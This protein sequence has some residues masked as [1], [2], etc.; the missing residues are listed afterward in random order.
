MEPQYN[1]IFKGKIVNGRDPEYAKNV[2]AA[3][4]KQKAP[5]VLASMNGGAPYIRKNLTLE[6]ARKFKAVFDKAGAR[7]QVVKTFKCPDCGHI[8]KTDGQC[9]KCMNLTMEFDS[10]PETPPADAPSA[11][12]GP[13]RTAA[14][15]P[16]PVFSTKKLNQFATYK[17]VFKGGIQP[18]FDQEAVKSNLGNEFRADVFKVNAP[19]A[20]GDDYHQGQLNGIQAGELRERFERAGAVVEVFETVKCPMCGR[21][22]EV[23]ENCPDCFEEQKS[24]TIEDADSWDGAPEIPK[25]EKDQA[26]FGESVSESEDFRQEAVVRFRRGAIIFFIIFAWNYYI[27]EG[28]AFDLELL[29]LVVT[30]PYLCRGCYFMAKAKGYSKWFWLFGLTLFFG[31]AIMFF[32]PDKSGGR[33]QKTGAQKPVY[34]REWV[35]AA[36]CLTVAAV[37]PLEDVVTHFRYQAALKQTDLIL[38]NAADMVL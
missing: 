31:V 16:Q 36:V 13:G 34:R 12:A 22:L 24:Q 29:G 9:E 25:V 17:L 10:A 27:G 5:K 37:F 6:Q 38:E 21:V 30:A 4:F 33:A 19:F 23:G 15:A 32:L 35:W 14:G 2:L 28:L 3:V 20:G 18:G 26:T 11:S 8:Q 7:I 1:I